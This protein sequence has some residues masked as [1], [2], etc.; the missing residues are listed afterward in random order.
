MRTLLIALTAGASATAPAQMPAIT[1]GDGWR[2]ET[3]AHAW[4]RL[5]VATPDKRQSVRWSYALGLLG[6]KRGA[7]A[8]GVLEVM[9]AGERDLEL[10]APFQLAR[11]MALT[12]IGHDAEAIAV[13][14][15]P[16]LA[17]NPEACAWRMRA[18]AHS[19]AAGEAVAQINCALPAINGRAPAER[20]PFVLAAAGAAIE[21]G[22]PQPA[23]AWLTLFSDHNPAANLL[24]GRALLAQKDVAGSRLRFERAALKGSPEIKADATLGTIEADLAGNG[25]N[26]TQAMQKLDALRYRWRGGQIEARALRLEDRLASDAHDLR[27][28]LR[29]G[30]T[31]LR[32][33]NLGKDAG[34]MLATLQASLAAAL[35]PE[36]GIPL[37]DAAGL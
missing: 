22:Q 21:A 9:R 17:G 20:A 35:A 30:A 3:G 16:S 36:S 32:Y 11:G 26:A 10:V 31:L 23:L 7:D 34:P 37:P 15:A 6:E 24:R 4:Q 14:A 2:G 12:L 29:T 25:I 28:Q 8:I 1:G 18:L 19:R 5:A 27:A 13:L 33:V